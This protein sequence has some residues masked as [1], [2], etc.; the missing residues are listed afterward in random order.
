M[1]YFKSIK[2]FFNSGS[3]KFETWVDNTCF[4]CEYFFFKGTCL[5]RYLRNK[6][7][8]LLSADPLSLEH[9]SYLKNLAAS[10]GLTSDNVIYVP[11]FI[12]NSPLSH[13]FDEKGLLKVF[14]FKLDELSA[15]TSSYSRKQFVNCMV[16]LSRLTELSVLDGT[17]LLEKHESALKT[18]VN[19]L[20]EYEVELNDF[21]M[22]HEKLELVD[23]AYFKA[24]DYALH[25]R[26][27]LRD[28][29]NRGGG[30]SFLHFDGVMMVTDESICGAPKEV[31][32]A[33][34]CVSF[35]KIW[36]AG[37]MKHG[38]KFGAYTVLSVKN[39]VLTIGCNKYPAWL[40]DELVKQFEEL[41]LM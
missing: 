27:S 30:L 22:S 33:S 26:K 18:A 21:I 16:S 41:E 40:F 20:K 25:F 24:G 35:L 7:T 13:N 14:A 12:H 23:I 32:N 19:G 10:S 37:K 34:D 38:M 4:N 1:G 6:G 9:S 11:Q 15:C 36:K 39:G 17:D 5:A 31:M 8:L 3:S 29:L 28:Y 2:L